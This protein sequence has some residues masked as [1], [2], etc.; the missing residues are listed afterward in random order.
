MSDFEQLINQL[1]SSDNTA[2]G[3]AE[4]SFNDAVKQAPDSLTMALIQAVRTSQATP[5]REMSMVLLRKTLISKESVEK[6]GQK[7]TVRFWSKLNASTQQTIKT[8][9]LAA[10]EQEPVAS[11]R[12]K[13]CDTISELALFL[14]AFGEVESDIMQQW[15]QLLP[16]LFRM[17]NSENDEHRKSSLDIFS[18]LCL[19]LGESL[20]T[21]FE[22]LKQVL[23][24]GLTDQKSLRVRMAALGACVSF[25]QLLE[26]NQ[27]KLTLQHWIPAMFEVVSTCLNHKKEDE[28]LDSLQILVELAD[29][30][31]TFLR[32]HLATVVNAMLT[33][34]NTS[35]LQDGIRQLGLEFLVT[36]AEQRAGMVRKVPNFVQNL[37]PVVLNF[38]LDIEDDAEWGSHDD[39]DEDE[40]EAT[41]HSVGSE[42]LDRLALS[43]GGKTLI[44]I[45]FDMIP[46]L[47]QAPEWKHRFTGLTAISLVGEGCH[48]FLVSHLES[49]IN[50]ILPRFA[51]PHPRVRWAACNTF[52]QMFTDF[53]PTIQAKHHDKV[54]PAL[55]SVMDDKDNPRVQSHAASA[56]I[57][58]CEATTIEILDPYLNTLLSKLAS[59]LQGGNKM[60]LEQAIT[61]IAALADV[62][63]G[64]F[65]SYYDTFMP[66]LKEVLRNANGKELRMLRGKTM[67]CISLIGVAVGKEKFYA[68]AKDV[69]QVLYATQQSKL[70][71]DDPQ[72]SFLLQA[73]ARVCKT[74]GQEFVPYLEVVM[75]PLLRSAG[76]DPDLTVQ[77]DDDGNAEQDGWQYIPIGDKRIG[78]NTSL[79][80]EKATACSMIYQY[81]A[82]LKEGFFPYVEQVA[83]LLIPLVKFYFHD[84]VRRAAVS[85]MSA[86]LQSVKSHL[87][88]SG[89]GTQPLAAL[90]GHILTNLNEAIQQEIDVELLALMLEILGECIDVCGNLMTEAQIRSVFETIKAEIGER[91]ERL[92]ARL[93]E[94]QSEDFDDEEA[95]KLEVENEKEDEVMAEIG[96]VIG[97]LAKTHKANILRS[98]SETL[99]PIAIQ[100]M[101]PQKQPHDRQIGLCM[102]DDMLEHCEGAA[103]PLYQ[104]FL[105]GMVNYLTDSN[106]SVR[107]AAVFGIGLCAQFGGPSMGTI[108]PDIFRRLD[109]V[110]KHNESRSAENVHATENAISAVGKIIRFQAAAIDLNQMFPIFLSYLPVTEDEVEAQVTYANLAIFIEQHAAIVV[111]NNYQNLPQL[112]SAMGT[113]IGTSLVT[114]ET[115]L[116]LIEIVKKL[117]QAVPADVIQQVMSRLTPEQATKITETIR[118]Q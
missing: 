26:S 86:L 110:I 42:S 79:M 5:V 27:E 116:K 37:V 51:D 22:T 95:E 67:E 74:L 88:I 96:E 12:K 80:E 65:I 73:W 109:S 18:K 45:L 94:K 117:A 91:E 70:E 19:Y 99:F 108:I 13:L 52:G 17:S 47:L 6:D 38:M 103:L 66:F 75:P 57:N 77:G 9:L 92:K 101:H 14:T 72:I 87:E 46:K 69:V 21:H 82:E 62:V 1:M 28:A 50:M 24:A 60:V 30:E 31:P 71:P 15:P 102:L 118:G 68:D 55:M 23:Q 85:A 25:V 33:I 100:L 111:G 106:P 84:G 20:G 11:G 89:Q 83:Q 48:R 54:L 43:L 7:Q 44:P 35:Q 112:L 61:A 39:D 90:F 4:K 53:G 76:L 49:V 59:L 81:A 34:A 29:V 58:F 97:K 107:Q 78:I 40:V 113:A 8:E 64:R 93:E 105:P 2:R 56:V 36:L 115:N 98:F 16:I 3:H 41:N 32:P 104:V 10:V 114:E 63:E